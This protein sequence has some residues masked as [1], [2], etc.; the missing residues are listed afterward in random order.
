[1][2]ELIRILSLASRHWRW[3]VGGVLLGV[4]VIILNSALMAVSGWFIASMAVAGVSKLSFNYFFASAS[5]RAL[6]ILRALGRYAE[7]LLTHDAAFHVLA[8]LRNWLFRRM[9]PLAPAGLEKYGSGELAGRLRADL[10]SLETVYLR[11]LA[12]VFSG[13]CAILLAVLFVSFW[14]GTASL[15]LSVMLIFG[16]LLLP[17]FTLYLAEQPG[18]ASAELSGQ[19]RKTVTE[20]LQGAEELLLL[21]AGSQQVAMVET[22]SANLVQKQV[23]L[24]K[25]AA[26]GLAGITATVG[27]SSVLIALVC[28]PLIGT[29]ELTP[30]NLVMLLLFSA[31]SFEAV[32]PLAHSLQLIPAATE[33]VRRI[34]E[35]ADAKV[36]FPDPLVSTQPATA[37]IVINDVSV[38]YNS[39]SFVLEHFSLQIKSGE[40][41]ALTGQSGTGKSTL[42]ELLLRFRPYQG[43]VT[44]S[45]CELSKISSDTMA[46]LVSAAPQKPHLFNRSIKENILLGRDISDDAL[47]ALLFDSGLAGWVATLPEGLDTMVGEFG[48]KV[49]GGE[50][51]RIA[52]ARALLSDSPILLLDEP[53]EGLDSVTEQ[54]VV[55][56]LSERLRGKTLLLATHR[57]ACLVMVER[58][59]SFG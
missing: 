18:R 55:E 46:R 17:L 13:G 11:I 16:G 12:P 36:P 47:S 24:G 53:T 37:D 44:I 29:G 45:G 9:I 27:L 21:G 54:F 33:A 49:S 38:A 43:S 59:V 14:S 31:A 34:R 41:V 39:D 48:S 2:R 52:L 10:D 15:V 32:A 51:R 5:I 1:M 42:I 3:M 28:I 20:G 25:I 6:A 7:R 56:R 4:L 23:R 22:V 8:D 19:L 57:P 30:P 35:L 58:V 50:A 26:L 40:R